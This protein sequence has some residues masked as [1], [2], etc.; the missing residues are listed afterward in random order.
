MDLQL[1]V[2][3][4]SFPGHQRQKR[5]WS[6]SHYGKGGRFPTRSPSSIRGF[7]RARASSVQRQARRRRHPD[8]ATASIQNLNHRLRTSLNFI[9][10]D[11]DTSAERMLVHLAASQH[12]TALFY[13]A[14]GSKFSG[15]SADTSLEWAVHVLDRESVASGPQPIPP[16]R[17]AYA[18]VVGLV[19]LRTP[20]TALVAAAGSLPRSGR[21]RSTVRATRVES[22]ERSTT[23]RRRRSDWRS[24]RRPLRSRDCSC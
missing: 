11:A 20:S 10:L 9:A 13:A 23:A 18:C 21:V 7:Q 8:R 15:T 5:C 22:S 1:T 17:T 12:P 16:S 19:H 4:A 14:G 6:T 2:P 3:A 24:R